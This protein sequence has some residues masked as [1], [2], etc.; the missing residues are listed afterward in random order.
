MKKTIARFKYNLIFAFLFASALI[1]P[2][3]ALRFSSVHLRIGFD[4]VF[5]SALAVFGFFLSLSGRAVFLSVSAVLFACQTVQL[6]YTAY[7]G[8]PLNPVDIH[9][10]FSE[11]P[12]IWAAGTGDLKDVWFVMPLLLATFGGTAFFFFKYG[13]RLGF[14]V[15]A[16]AVVLCAL[17]AKPER[18]SRKSLKHFLPAATRNT[19]HNSLNT[20]SYYLVKGR[21]LPLKAVVPQGLY[22]PVFAKRKEGETPR[23]VMLV[24]GESLTFGHMGVFGYSRP[25]TP[26]L[27][28]MKSNPDFL[29]AKGVSSAVSTHSA[30][31]IFFD[32]MNEPGNLDVLKDDPVN[33]FRLA[34][35][36]GYKTHWLS[37]QD[38]KN[39]HSIGVV[40][41][42]D[43][44]TSETAPVL[45]SRFREDYLLHLLEKLD[46]SEGR[47]FVV[48]H[49]R[50]AH[51][52]YE[53]NYA[54]RKPEFSKYP[55]NGGNRR[56]R[57]VNAYDNAVLYTDSIIR[58]AFEIFKQKEPDGGVF[59]VTS[60]HG[61]LLG[62]DGL[63]GHNIFKREAFSV[64]F[65]I[66]MA[67]SDKKIY[68]SLKRRQFVSHYR[69]GTV[70]A[71]VMGWEI[72]NPN[73]RD[74]EFFIHGN[75]IFTDYPLMTGTF[76]KDGDFS[77]SRVMTLSEYSA[78]RASR[79]D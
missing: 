20:F 79:K 54:H 56:T 13:K 41:I 63:F 46:L 78:L 50:T 36:A 8:R 34:K 65:I 55:T 31:P 59:M 3:Y 10:I 19:V 5:F 49:F 11:F 40:H 62:E 77:L 71:D 26:F 75:D 9:K 1:L 39:T 57:M 7:S 64:P 44:R 69:M 32:L 43:L 30:L 14:S 37:A 4:V 18:A 23:V 60:D 76:G 38:A 72:V 74:E 67:H 45:F 51:S 15:F 27:S 42:D 25:T 52:P 12:D 61:Q 58:R 17:A 21:S 2:D 68:D 73:C 33:L 29:F 24:M 47:H 35:K 16:V 28:E 48:L 6:H 22:R 66:Y 53:S 70:L